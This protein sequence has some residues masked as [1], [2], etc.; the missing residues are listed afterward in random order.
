VA[1][2]GHET[3]V[4]IADLA[5]DAR[6][7]TP[8]AAAML[9]FP[10]RAALVVQLGRD[11]G[12]LS[13]AIESIFAAARAR[14]GHEWQ[15]LRAHAPRARLAAQ[16]ARLAAAIGL[17]ERVARRSIERARDGLASAA[18][19][20]DAL[21]PLAVLGRGYAI[22]RLGSGGPVVRSPEQVKAG[23]GLL[24]R[25]AEG[26]IEATVDRARGPS[27]RETS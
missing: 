24:V 10:D 19:R 21:S 2:V 18:A 12:R 23:E 17:L 16:R 8:S 15:A 5:A 25:V 22:V 6:A 20:L 11:L 4:T 13:R 14:L 26:E 1:G 9:A 7:P 3:D 27:D